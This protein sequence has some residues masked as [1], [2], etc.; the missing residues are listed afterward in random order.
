MKDRQRS[1]LKL[2]FF[3]RPLIK[4]KN[5]KLPENK[6]SLLIFNNF[7]ILENL[8]SITTSNSIKSCNLQKQ[9]ENS[10]ENSIQRV[11]DM[12]QQPQE[13][14][15]QQN[16]NLLL[17]KDREMSLLSI[18]EKIFYFLSVSSE[19]T[20]HKWQNAPLS[21]FRWDSGCLELFLCWKR[22]NFN[23]GNSLNQCIW[24]YAYEEFFI[25]DLWHGNF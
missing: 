15:L 25:F 9:E 14:Y 13:I 19:Q 11:N 3:N 4:K 6:E 21:K 12:S 7:R 18:C 16:D 1:Q 2:V 8:P 20:T 23:R 24:T 22:C 17:K 5:H 10:R